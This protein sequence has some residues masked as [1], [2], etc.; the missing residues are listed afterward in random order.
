[1]AY[2]GDHYAKLSLPLG[3]PG[4]REAQLAAVQSVAGHFFGSEVPAIVVM[5]TGS[6]KTIVAATL[7]F[8]LR[9]QRVLVLTPSRLVR[10]QIAEKFSTLEDL[11]RIGA[12]PILVDKP[13]VKTVAHRIRTLEDWEAMRDADVVVATVSSVSGIKNAVPDAPGDLFDLVIVDEGHHAPAVTW[14]R[15]LDHLQTAKQ[16]I[17]TATP[18]R[19]D[20]K[21]IR[22]KLTFVYTVRR[23]VEDHV[24]GNL[25]FEPVEPAAGESADVAIARAAARRLSEDRAAGLD[26]LIMVRV[27]SIDRGRALQQV[28]SDNTD[29]RLKFISGASALSTVKKTVEDM[30][31]GNLDGVI[32]VNMFG[33]GFD[34]PRLKIAALH[35]PHKSLAVTLQFIGRFARTNDEHIGRATFIA[36]PEEQRTELRELWTP[37]APWPDFVQNLAEARVAEEAVTRE[38][39]SSFAVN[40]SPDLGDL[41]LTNIQPYYHVKIFYCPDGVDLDAAVDHS[42]SEA[43]V[44]RARSDTFGA[45]VEITQTTAKP[46]WSDDSRIQNV[47]YELDVL[48]YNAEHHLLFI[49]SSRKTVDHYRRISAAVAVGGRMTTLSAAAVNRVLNDIEGIQFFSVG[50]RKRQFGGRS[51]SY[52]MMAGPSADKSVDEADAQ[53]FD[54]GH[55][56]GKGRSAGEEITIGL[57]T[58]SKVWSNT[59]DVIPNLIKW[60][61]ALAEKIGSG[62]IKPTGSGLDHLS[63]GETVTRLDEQIIFAV[64][65]SKTYADSPVVYTSPYDLASARGTLAGYDI[66][67]IASDETTIHFRLCSAGL[68]WDGLYDLNSLP[69]I[70]PYDDSEEEPHLGGRQAQSE[71]LISDYLSDIPPRFFTASLSAVEGASLFRPPVQSAVLDNAD[72]T[73]IDWTEAGVDIE[74]EKP[75]DAETKGCSIFAWLEARLEATSADLIF[76]DDGAGEIADYVTVDDASNDPL[77]TFYHCKASGAALAGARVNDLYDVC[78]QAVRSGVWL[79]GDRL[80]D[81]VDYRVRTRGTQN[82]K[83]GRVDVLRSAFAAERRQRVKFKLVIVQPG[84]SASVLREGSNQLLVATKNYSKTSGFDFFEVIASE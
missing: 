23:A 36:Y 44:F 81:R 82:L 43:T 12:L 14:S 74:L 2:F 39:L 58:S 83:R 53:V 26:H 31:A 57:S 54:R 73:I 52:R 38:V 70:R 61:D 40:V 72:F 25:T 42:S 69:L 5:P 63:A 3:D 65:A 67:I 28:Y 77:V 17:L 4:F 78:G 21:E 35:A 59:T 76:L 9:A 47:N 16:V 41:R 24:F 1:V 13:V 37:G 84:I 27:D 66:E 60:C 49:C 50:M 11:Q 71:V 10:E 45:A 30:K 46:R 8:V 75:S 51:E 34:L 20:A 22:G 32:C 62:I 79:A 15:I 29:L 48:H 56:F 18:F 7:A 6:G 80:V 68:T 33:E 19:Q 64:F 55:S